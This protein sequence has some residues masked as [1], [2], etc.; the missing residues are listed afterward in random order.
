MQTVSKKV[1]WQPCCASDKLKQ[2]LKG[3]SKINKKDKTRSLKGLDEECFQNFFNPRTI[4]ARFIS[5]RPISY[6]VCSW[7]YYTYLSHNCMFWIQQFIMDEFK[8]IGGPWS[9]E[10][11]VLKIHSETLIYKLKWKK[12]LAINEAKYFTT[13]SSLNNWLLSA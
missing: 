3:G 8:N 6:S 4:K 10:M 12:M 2:R 13:H 7:K 1:K 5:M 9:L 11:I